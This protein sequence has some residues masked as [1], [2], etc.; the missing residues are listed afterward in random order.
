M[1]I[2]DGAPDHHV[3]MYLVPVGDRT[4]LVGDPRLAQEELAGSERES[5]EVAAYLPGGPAFSAATMAA[6]DGVAEQCR[7]AGYR[8]VRIPVVPGSDGRTYLTYVNCI[9][10]ERDGKRV[11]YMP[12]YSFADS[13][14]RQAA[15]VWAE[16]GYEVRPVECDSCARYFGTLHCLVNVL[17][18]D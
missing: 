4:V 3:A 6:F 18:R 7:A 14:N 11:V 8:V 12:V 16:L 9:Q 15:A 17:E 13:L 2:L 5:A 10:D 1:V